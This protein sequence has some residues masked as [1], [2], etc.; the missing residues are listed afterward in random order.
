MLFDINFGVCEVL[1]C[2]RVCVRL[3]FFLKLALVIDGG[4]LEFALNTALQ[5]RFVRL[6]MN[7]KV[8]LCCRATP[9]QKV[10]TRMLTFKIPGKSLT[11]FGAGACG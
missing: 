11:Y 1:W 3:T 6:L 5:Q 7:C 9:L 10:P 2:V 4:T 8:V